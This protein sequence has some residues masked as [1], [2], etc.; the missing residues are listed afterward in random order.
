MS[1]STG[2]GKHKSKTHKARKAR[3]TR[4]V[5]KWK[6]F[7]KKTYL[8]MKLKNKNTT[9]EEAFKEASDQCS[10]LGL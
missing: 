1:Y 9:F 10:K 2:R 3:K 8:E 7:V 6:L 5:S 4:K